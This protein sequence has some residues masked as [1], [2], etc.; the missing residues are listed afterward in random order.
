M[1]KTYYFEQR[2]G[3]MGIKTRTSLAVNKKSVNADVVWRLESA[4]NGASCIWVQWQNCGVHRWLSK[5]WKSCMCSGSSHFK[6]FSRL[7]NRTSI[8]TS[9]LQAILYAVVFISS[10]P[11]QYILYSDSMSSVIVLRS[12]STSTNQVLHKIYKE[13]SKLPED[14]LIIEWV[15]SHTPLEFFFQEQSYSSI[16]SGWSLAWDHVRSDIDDPCGAIADF[17]GVIADPWGDRRPPMRRRRSLCDSLNIVKHSKTTWNTCK[18]LWYIVK[19][20]EPLVKHHETLIK[21]CET[22]WNTGTLIIR[23]DD[24]SASPLWGDRWTRGRRSLRYSLNIIKHC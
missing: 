14:K 22:L 18:T 11:G 4:C 13:I 2:C 16:H 8:F 23:C 17:C 9:E 19:H 3:Y 21:H 20:R 15:P 12:I 5:T 7:K 1:F 6:L 24:I 10:L